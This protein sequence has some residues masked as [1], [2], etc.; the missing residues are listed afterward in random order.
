[1]RV[2]TELGRVEYDIVIPP[3]PVPE[4]KWGEEGIPGLCLHPVHLLGP[5]AAQEALLWLLGSEVGLPGP[6]EETALLS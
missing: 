6:F 5:R 4:S 3:V 2:G 1:M